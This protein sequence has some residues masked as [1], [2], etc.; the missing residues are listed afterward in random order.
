MSCRWWLVV[1]V[2]T[3]S[4][5]TLPA[6]ADDDGEVVAEIGNEKIT[7]ADLERFGASIR[8]ALSEAVPTQ[9]DSALLRSLIDKKALLMA[10]SEQGIE[11]EPWFGRAVER[12]RKNKLIEIYQYLEVTLAISIT[13]EDLEAHFKATHRDRAL[14]ISGILLATRQEAK[15]VLTELAAGADFA[16]LSKERSLYE[17]ARDIGGDSEQYLKKDGTMKALQGIFMLEVG[18]TSEPIPVP[19]RGATNFAVIK[20]TDSIPIELGPIPLTMDRARRQHPWIEE[21]YV[22]KKVA[23]Q[24][25]LLDSL[26]AVY[27]PR[28]TDQLQ[29]LC[30]RI[31]AD[32]ELDFSTVLDRALCVY[33]G[34][35][36]TFGDFTTLVPEANL[37]PEFL[38]RQSH[39]ESFLNN[40][41]IPA[42]LYLEEVRQRTKGEENPR[43]AAMAARRGEDLLLSTA[44][45]RGVD[46]RIA[47]PSIEEA[48]E[49]YETHPE[50]FQTNEEITVTE[51]LVAFRELAQQLR[52]QLD[53]GEDVEELARA[54]TIR[55]GIAHHGGRL[56]LSKHFRHQDVYEVAKTMDV[57][58]VGGPARVEG[59]FSV[60][61]V[62]EKR[63]SET[64]PFDAESQRRAG[65]YLR[66][67]KMG[68]G[69]VEYVREL[70]QKYGTRIHDD[71]LR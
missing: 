59:G 68:R 27:S 18:E 57:G 13:R 44:R 50:Q 6:G 4:L 1:L 5:G 39:V 26:L 71:S 14:R 47:P 16:Q 19:Y 69:Y 17:L 70:R 2:L 11:V 32:A 42:H 55:Q 23:R 7:R 52:E 22:L 20:V 8:R 30:K 64:K 38:S 56:E 62:L 43:V 36:L 48:M 46:D 28:Q 63:P 12:F 51:I 31:A 45:Q 10:A 3:W 66:I 53:A 49:Y 25:A 33:D 15:E 54:H 37:K 24:E 58:Q 29:E 41:A 67:E 34:G 21:L 61:K 9:S 60:F 35:S 40:R 65:G